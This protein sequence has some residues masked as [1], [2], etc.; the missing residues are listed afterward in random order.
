MKRLIFFLCA[1]FFIAL[2]VFAQT[3]GESPPWTLGID[4]MTIAGVAAFT[5]VI[6]GY[7]KTWFK[8]E[9]TWARWVSWIVAIGI[10]FIC[11]LLNLGLYETLSLPVTLVYGL[12]VGLVANGIFTAEIVQSWLEKIGAQPKAIPKRE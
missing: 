11:Y 4:L 6:A 9:G 12:G 5:L 8:L 2:P 7:L 3:A 10:S 1:M